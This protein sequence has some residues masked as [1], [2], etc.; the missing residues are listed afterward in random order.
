M[1]EMKTVEL[2]LAD[3][4]VEKL[5]REARSRGLSLAELVETSVEEKLS[6]EAEFGAATAAVLEK[7]SELYRRLA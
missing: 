2:H 5:E 6:R 3:D 1:T 4:L 7:N